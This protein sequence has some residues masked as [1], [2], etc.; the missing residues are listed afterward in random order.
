MLLEVKNMSIHYD[1]FLAVD[2]ISIS[3]DAQEIVGVVG[4]NGAG[5]SSIVRAIGGLVKPQ[6]G[7]IFF[8]RKESNGAAISIRFNL[9]N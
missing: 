7:Q 4:A 9:S 3:I 6:M 8:E 1:G 5:K 2:D